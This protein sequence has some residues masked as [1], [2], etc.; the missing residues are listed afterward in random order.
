M[1][2]TVASE[3]HMSTQVNCV[4]VDADAQNQQEL[5]GFLANYGVHIVGQ[6]SAPDTL[7]AMLGRSDAP[8]LAIVN[9]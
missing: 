5:T 2:R 4:I 1:V 3:L 9:L 6:L 8:Q 7:G